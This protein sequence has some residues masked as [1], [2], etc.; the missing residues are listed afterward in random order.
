[1]ASFQESEEG[2]MVEVRLGTQG[3][4]HGWY[5][6]APIEGF[7]WEEVEDFLDDFSGEAIQDGTRRHDK[8]TTLPWNHFD[9]LSRDRNSRKEGRRE[10]SRK[11]LEKIK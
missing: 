6:P 5:D 10:Q 4:D 3:G 7:R 9:R 8:G 2:A 1:M 11:G